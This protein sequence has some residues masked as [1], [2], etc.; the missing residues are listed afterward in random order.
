MA[1]G[2]GFDVLRDHYAGVAQRE[3]EAVRR[4]LAVMQEVI[5][6]VH[7]HWRAM[8]RQTRYCA[9]CQRQHLGAS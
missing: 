2:I 3:L 4:E 1:V 9:I 5:G 7:D 8:D 6:K